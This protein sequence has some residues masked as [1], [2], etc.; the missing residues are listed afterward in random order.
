MALTD[1]ALWQRLRDLPIGPPEAALSFTAR[2]A[3][4][5]GW[6][7]TAAQALMLEYRRFLY[8][9]AV[10]PDP[11]TPADAVDQAW[12][13]HLTYTR[14]YWRDLCRDTLGR[15]L[16]HVPTRGGAAEQSRFR[17]QYA[18]TLARYQAEFDQPPP[19]AWWPAPE[20]RF[21]DADRF[22]RVNRAS[23]WLLP[24]PAR[25]LL[26]ALGL[27]VLALGL[28]ACSGGEEGYGILFWFK[29]AL[30]VFVLYKLFS[31]LDGG[32]GGGS[33]SGCSGCG[34]CG[35]CGGD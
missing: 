16:H 26:A 33:G 14:S 35:G 15:E 21:Q 34:G 5:N 22:V 19:V 1:P 18:A 6:T 27:G 12:H 13:L 7:E 17:D 20:R 30:G 2:L 23:T 11:L 24:R 32:R 10:S 8:L 31:W 9:L 25:P 3:R 29:V 28:V 4:E